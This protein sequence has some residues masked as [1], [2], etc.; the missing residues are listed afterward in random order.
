[1]TKPLATIKIGQIHTAIW[2]N[3]IRTAKGAP[4]MM[5]NVSVERRY[6]DRDGKWKSTNNFSRNDVPVVIYCLDKALEHMIEHSSHSQPSSSD[7]EDSA[8]SDHL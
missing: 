7:D 3:P 4:A 5:L 2:E 6:R 8:H 1:M